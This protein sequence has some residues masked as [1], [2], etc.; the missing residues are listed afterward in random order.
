[1]KEEPVNTVFHQR[2]EEIT[3]KKKTCQKQ[4]IHFKFNCRTVNEI[5]RYWHKQDRYGQEVNTRKEIEKLVLKHLW[6][7]ISSGYE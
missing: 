5:A 4:Q 1:M 6:R 3:T 7:L 2:P